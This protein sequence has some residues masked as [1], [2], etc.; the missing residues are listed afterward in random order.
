MRQPFI[1]ALG[2]KKITRNLLVAVRLSSGMTGY[3]EASASLAWPADHQETMTRILQGLFP[4]LIG[5]PIRSYRRLIRLT[6][7]KASAHP[8]AA[9]ALE[10]ALVDAAARAEETC[11]WCWFGG[12]THSV[13]TGLTLSAWKTSFAA[14]AAE[15]AARRGFR[16]FKI[17]VT[18][19]DLDED[20]RRV[21]AVAKAVP[22]ASLLL[23]GNQG[24]RPAEAV[25]FA[26]SLRQQKIRVK[27]FEQPVVKEDR[28]GL[29]KVQ[30]EGRIPV[31]ADESVR[32]PQELRRLLRKGKLFGVNIKVAKSGLTGAFEMIRIARSAGMKRLIGCMAESA[33]G[34][35]HSVALAC[36]TNAFD[37]IDL[38]SHLLVASPECQPGFT[39]R[40][41]RLWVRKHQWGSGIELPISRS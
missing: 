9:A 30:R 32:N 11:L 12:K 33:I 8:T 19:Q 3:G 41:P 37:F 27:L 18:G 2:Q 34:L 40:G 17:K 10:C 1:T 4:K 21:A 5:V 22:R 36:G 25:R 14:G 15:S 16:Q 39:S 31:I 35:T 13:T 7:E 23:D 28:E 38:D 20:F 6:W 24:F 29:F 26:I